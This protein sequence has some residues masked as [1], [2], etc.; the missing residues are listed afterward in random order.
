MIKMSDVERIIV[1]T[2]EMTMDDLEIL[3][4]IC[5]D[6]V[7][8]WAA[9]TSPPGEVKPV[10]SESWARVINGITDVWKKADNRVYDDLVSDYDL[11]SDRR[12]A[13]D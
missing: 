11:A 10:L 9:I 12:G 13:L 1:V 5:N 3:K 8:A 4:E 2:L 7:R 6:H